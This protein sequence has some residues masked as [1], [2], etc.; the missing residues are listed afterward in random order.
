MNASH[1]A[2][3]WRAALLVAL[4]V[5]ATLV[6]QT[7]NQPQPAAGEAA[8][9][10]V[11]QLSPFTVSAETVGRYATTE[12]TSGSRVAVPLMDSTQHVSVV[13]RDLM[14]DIGIGRLLDAAKYVAGVSEA[15]IPN[16][17]DR[18]NLRGF[19][20]DGVT[21][22]GFAYFS[23]GQLDPVV[24][25]RIEVVKGPNAI[26]APQGIPGG[27]ENVVSKRPTF[28][29]GGYVSAEVGQWSGE[30]F[31]FDVNQV[32]AP[33]KAA[34]RVVGAAQDGN[35]YPGDPDFHRS[36]IVMPM[37][38]YRF[39]PATQLTVQVEAY[40]YRQLDYLGIPLDPTVGTNDAARLISGVPR[41]AV[42]IDPDTYRYQKAVHARVFFTSNITD[43][44]AMRLAGNWIASK[45]SSAQ[46][47]L[48]GSNPMVIN[49]AT[50]AY[51]AS[52]T[53]TITRTYTRSF[54]NN[55]QPRRNFDLQNDFLYH[56]KSNSVDSRTV[57]GYWLN[58]SLED[59]WNYNYSKP[60]FNIDA[61]TPAAPTFTGMGGSPTFTR[62]VI[63]GYASETLSLLDDHL[64]LNG[65]VAQASYQNHNFNKTPT[66]SDIYNPASNN[67]HATMPSY[68][69]VVKPVR[70]VSLFYGFSKQSTA[71]DPSTTTLIPYKLQTS[72][73]NEYGMRIQVLGNKIYATVS[74]FDIKQNNFSVPNPAN[75]TVPPPVPTLPPLFMD[76]HAHGW[77]FEFTAALTSSFS[78]I[79]NYTSF[80]NRNPFD[81]VFR[82]NAEKSGAVWGSYA[83][84]D[85]ALKG[86]TVGVG[87]DYLDRRPGDAPSGSPTSAS[88]PTHLIM[89][90]PTFWLPARTLVNASI[91]YSWAKHYRIQLNLDNITN[92][93]YLAAAI[94]RNM[95]V[96]GTPFD[97]RL[98]VTY[99]F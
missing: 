62:R 13:T 52:P 53:A 87:L 16:A 73:Q 57:F 96:P 43:N 3:V 49:P 10:D 89:P 90:Q 98:T 34:L 66:A 19:Q 24:V 14:N 60:A 91:S 69:V 2:S 75:L 77:E 17:Q 68:G 83:V 79:G 20:V 78:L 8:G 39:S 84:K 31:E 23:F 7:Q 85:G 1:D 95:V 72:R 94:N 44:F 15:T 25:D 74:H 59:Q 33:G 48:S 76:R 47:N 22:D 30:R 50:G 42:F 67:Q 21:L 9:A 64:I 12:A 11:V 4:V 41:S 38:T 61:Y 70:E 88:T 26:L 58:Q 35:D 5:P 54:T 99:S 27:T 6:A 92:Q 56:L 81:Q 28:A 97:A 80:K 18:T 93:D 29:N 82:G 46:S 71:I 37:V 45:A 65:G 55:V 32:L 51:S 36:F 63:Q 40:S 86:L